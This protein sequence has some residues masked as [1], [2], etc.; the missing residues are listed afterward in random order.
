M[1]GRKR[2]TRASVTWAHSR[3]RGPHRQFCKRSLRDS[4]DIATSRL[5]R[6]WTSIPTWPLAQP[7]LL[8]PKAALLRCHRPEEVP[9]DPAFVGQINMYLSAVEDLLRH[10]DDKPTIGLLFCRSKD[11]MV[12]E[13]A[14]RDRKKPIGGAG[15]ATKI[16]EELPE[17]IKGSL[18][19]VEEIW[20]GV[21]GR[22]GR[23]ISL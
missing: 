16:V 21:R 13:Y 23:T 7:V 20:G 22:G 5:P 19:T 4:P 12:F 17:S 6:S 1:A 8:P 3:R 15:W 10:P 18:P 14:L 11:M 2:V 9:F